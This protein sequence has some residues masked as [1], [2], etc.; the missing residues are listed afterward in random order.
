MKSFIQTQILRTFFKGYNISFSV[1]YKKNQRLM[2]VFDL[3]RVIN[4]EPAFEIDILDASGDV[5]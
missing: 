2:V 3:G 1:P 4:D 5:N